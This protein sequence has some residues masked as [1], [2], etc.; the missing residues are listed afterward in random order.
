MS[1]ISCKYVE[2]RLRKSNRRVMMS[3]GECQ[4]IKRQTVQRMVAEIATVVK[5]GSSIIRSGIQV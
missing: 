4:V 2:R 3:F 5:S 1:G